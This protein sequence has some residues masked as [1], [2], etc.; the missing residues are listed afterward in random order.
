[1]KKLLVVLVSIFM[2]LSLA[3]CGSSSDDS[4]STDGAA[5]S[6]KIGAS[7]PLSGAAAQYGEAA[8]NGA[9]MAVEEIN[10]KEGYDYFTLEYE[11][12][13]H[14]PELAVNCFNTLMD[15]GMQVS[16][17]CVTSKPCIAVAQKYADEHV[18]AL[19]PS[20]SNDAIVT[21]GDNLFQMCF[22]D[23]NQGLAAAEYILN[24]DDLK[25]MNIGVFYNSGDDYSIGIY[26][27]FKDTLEAAGVEVVSVQSFDDSSTDYNTQVDALKAAD[28]QLLFMPIYY[29]AAA[30]FFAAASQKEYAPVA[31]G[32]DGMDGI[33]G[34]V[35]AA[36]VEGTYLLY[37]YT[38]DSSDAAA[39]FTANYKEEFGIDPLQFAGDAYDCVYALYQACKAGGVTGDMTAS[40]ICDILTEQF[41]TMTFT[42]VTAT[43]ATWGADG[44]ISKLPAA[45]V[46]TDGEY[47]LAD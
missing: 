31:Y 29:D 6:I 18:F 32:V 41:T 36:D 1:M 20:G 19:T 11:D 3:G 7:G 9:T 37:P 8:K 23:S 45:V 44:Y 42:G 25:A 10:E 35:D 33:L 30:N 24:H 15:N 26:N 21:Y 5:T 47:V 39:D 22:S 40:E 27:K 2:V 13:Q 46:I 14:D 43:D 12:D 28:V 17:F 38:A 34:M 4:A 16:L